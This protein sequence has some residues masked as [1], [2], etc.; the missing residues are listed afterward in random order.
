MKR[1]L[2][3]LLVLLSGC[4]LPDPKLLKTEP[5]TVPETTIQTR[6]GQTFQLV[7]PSLGASPAYRWVLDSSYDST[8]LRLSQEGEATSEYPVRPPRGYAPNRLYVFQ[9]L[10]VGTIRLNFSQQALSASTPA[11]DLKR[12]FTIVIQAP[13]DS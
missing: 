6:V 8:L 9:A 12:S 3:C 10:A 2:V 4:V 1:L 11:V 7:L 13:L 5:L